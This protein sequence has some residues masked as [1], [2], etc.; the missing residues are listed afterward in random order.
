LH[1]T[2]NKQWNTAEEVDSHH[3]DEQTNRRSNTYTATVYTQEVDLKKILND[4]TKEWAI[5]IL[6]AVEVI[7]GD[8]KSFERFYHCQR[9]D[10][11][12]R[13]KQPINQNNFTDWDRDK[14]FGFF[15]GLTYFHS[16]FLL[17]GYELDTGD[18]EE[19]LLFTLLFTM[20]PGVPDTW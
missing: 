19:I 6:N 8:S 16:A 1:N 20:C 5:K 7:L 13:A 9:E 3:I 12:S 17:V 14:A 2:V 11:S 15:A 10:F 18:M 4:V